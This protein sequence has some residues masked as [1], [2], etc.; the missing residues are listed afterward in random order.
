MNTGNYH[1]D[2]CSYE[3]IDLANIQQAIFEQRGFM[4]TLEVAADIWQWYSWKLSASWLFV[5][6]SDAAV[7]AYIES[8]DNFETWGKLLTEIHEDKRKPNS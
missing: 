8:A 2:D 7:V 4:V 1:F 5:P 3:L 6:E